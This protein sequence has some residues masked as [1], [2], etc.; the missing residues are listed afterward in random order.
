F[1]V[2][3]NEA[4]VKAKAMQLGLADAKGEVNEA[5]KVMA[6]QALM[7][8]QLSKA[9]GDLARTSGSTSNQIKAAKD[10]NLELAQ[11][12]GKFV[13][14]AVGSL[15]QAWKNLAEDITKALTA[16]NKWHASNSGTAGEIKTLNREIAARQGRI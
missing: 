7:T 10:Q 8:E 2:L 11:A 4:T 16:L 5:G 9:H 15:S 14:P 13:T 1:G 3:I 6:R 12:F